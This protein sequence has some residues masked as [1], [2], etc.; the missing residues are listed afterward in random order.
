MRRYLVGG[1]LISGIAAVALAVGQPSGAQSRPDQPL[2][3]QRGASNLIEGFRLDD[4]RPQPG[5]GN[6]VESYRLGE[7]PAAQGETRVERPA[8]QAAQPEQTPIEAAQPEAPQAQAQA[9]EARPQPPEARQAP[10]QPGAGAQA[11]TPQRGGSGIDSC[12]G[13]MN[14]PGTQACMQA[15][16]DCADGVNREVRCTRDKGQYTCYCLTDPS[17]FTTFQSSDHCRLGGGQSLSIDRARFTERVT[18]ACG[19][20]RGSPGG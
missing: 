13:W 20:Q 16:T 6:I 19:W 9:P 4:S 17:R 10:A 5:A 18:S 2:P 1:F 8:E 3:V 7:T 12:G 14:S 11:R 15:W